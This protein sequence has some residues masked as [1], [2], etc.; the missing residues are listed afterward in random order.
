MKHINKTHI[1]IGI[2]LL[3]FFLRFQN[4]NWDANMHLHPDERFLTMVG[5]SMKLPPDF[6][7]YLT[8]SISKWNPSNIGFSFFVY[9][10][11]PLTINKIIAIIIN[12]DFYNIFTIQ[13]RALSG[14][15]D[16]IALLFVYKLALVIKKKYKLSNLFPL[17][18][19]FLYAIAV[20]P[21]QSA[22]FFTTDTFLNIFLIISFYCATVFYFEERLI[23]FAG[24]SIFFAF[25]L[26]SKMSALYMF[27]VI[28]LIAV[29][30]VVKKKNLLSLCQY[31]CIY[32]LVF[33]GVLRIVSPYYFETGDIFN[34][35]LNSQFLKSILELR[36]MASG[37]MLFPPAVQWYSKTPFFFSLFNLSFFGLGI[38][39]FILSV[40]GGFNFLRF[41]FQQIKKKKL[42]YIIDYILGFSIIVWIIGYFV[43]NSLQFVQLT[44]YLLFL[45][46]FFALLGGYQLSLIQMRLK[47]LFPFVLIGLLSWP[48]LFSTIYLFQNT[49]ILSSWWIYK[50]IPNN[51][52]I[53]SEYWDDSL[54]YP[55]TSGKEFRNE[56]MH[57][58]DPD[59]EDKWNKMNLQLQNADYYI[60]SS[61]RAWGSIPTVPEK[62][63]KMSMYY[64][65]L[66][67][68]KTHFA[69][70]KRFV[71]FYQY[72]FP[73]HPTSWINNWFEEAFTVYDHPS[74][75]IFK[76][77]N[78]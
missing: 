38:F 12:T 4:L 53:L 11:F 75:F 51:A 32:L 60:L 78:K 55:V 45:F 14:I 37:K 1:L 43:Y 21:I 52:L 56:Q 19:A 67:N 69:L 73:F 33:Y 36:Y 23:Y 13:G 65:D 50:N 7:T 72:Y 49:R 6:T 59:T 27:P 15:M 31:L 30:P 63:P 57:V 64:A 29:V 58:F 2:F 46:P 71:P 25:A 5:N 10:L 62:Y 35:T 77:K 39:Y 40:L 34:I 76:N 17:F 22:H 42:I 74:V 68:N 66:F 20:Y 54:P 70:V 8:S 28:G 24:S 3:A 44:R 48:L 9:G 47:K 26:A 61:N 16:M 41:V 18:S